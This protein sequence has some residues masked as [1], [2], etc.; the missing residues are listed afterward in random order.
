VTASWFQ[1]VLIC[2]ILWSETGVS[3]FMR[4]MEIYYLSI[5]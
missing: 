1:E 5:S 4:F 2:I 3:P